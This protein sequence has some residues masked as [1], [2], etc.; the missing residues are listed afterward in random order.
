MDVWHAVACGQHIRVHVA[1]GRH[2]DPCPSLAIAH[3]LD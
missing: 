3:T 2:L 1:R